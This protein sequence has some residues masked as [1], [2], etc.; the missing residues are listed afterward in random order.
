M[1][2]MKTKYSVVPVSLAIKPHFG[3]MQQTKLLPN[4]FIVHQ[5]IQNYAPFVIS[6]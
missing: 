1:V 6:A 5:N 4:I 3:N 2:S